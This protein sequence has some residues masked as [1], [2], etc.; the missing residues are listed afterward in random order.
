MQCAAQYIEQKKKTKAFVE[1]CILKWHVDIDPRS[2]IEHAHKNITGI[3]GLPLDTITVRLAGKRA[4]IMAR[5]SICFHT[6]GLR[7]N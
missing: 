5:T 2:M 7:D 3:P 6:A 4:S 1:H